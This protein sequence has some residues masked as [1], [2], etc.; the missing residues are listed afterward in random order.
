MFKRLLLGLLVLLLL[1]PALQA[2]LRFYPEGEL[3]GAF[4]R[5]PHPE[6]SWEGLQSTAYQEALGRY[7]EDRL[8]FRTLAIR[9]H[10]QLSFSLFRVAG[11]TDLT[12]GEHEVLFQPGPIATYAGQDLLDEA[13][14]RFR[15]RRLRIVQQELARRG[16]KLLFVLA[17]NKARFQPE[18]LPLRLRPAPG[19]LTNYDLF[20]RAMRAD[21]LALL[22]LVP[23]FARWKTTK[24]YPLFPRAGTHWSGYGATLAADTLLRHLEQLGGLRFPQVRTVGSPRIISS[25]DSL[26]ATDN[27]LGWPLNLLWQREATPLAYRRLAFLPPQAGQTRPSALFIGDSF[28]WGLMQFSPYIQRE[29]SEDTRFWYYN[30]EVHLP[31]STYHDTGERVAKLNLQQQLESRRFVILLFTEHNLKDREYGFTDQVYRLYHPLTA[32]DQ[33]AIDQLAQKLTREASWEE[34]TKDLEGFQQRIRA[35]AQDLYERQLLQ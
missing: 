29:F 24:P 11:L 34:Q 10:N 15:V 31:D 35:K 7:V 17:P 12:V 2:R 25:S 23:V 27:D 14:V 3:A 21:S 13:E 28:T 30:N 26:L 5:A 18:D 33:A 32:T 6:F 20:T 9:L 19:I 1:L 16:V 4:T 22:D 8:G